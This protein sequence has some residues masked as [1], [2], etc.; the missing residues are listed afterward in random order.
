[1]TMEVIGTVLGAIGIADILRI[2]VVKIFAKKKDQITAS[3]DE[4]EALR[5]RLSYTEKEMNRLNKAQIA[6]NRKISRLYSYLVNVTTKTCTK[7]NCALREIMAID[8]NDFD[9]DDES[10]SEKPV[11]PIEKLTVT[12]DQTNGYESK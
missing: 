3:K 7:K 1:M 10:T 2:I 8:F 12:M 11:I 9:D 5:E 6:A 4:F